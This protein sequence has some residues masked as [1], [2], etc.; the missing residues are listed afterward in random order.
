MSVTEQRR[1]W[2]GGPVRYG[3]LID[4]LKHPS[5]RRERRAVDR[6]T[7][8]GSLRGVGADRFGFVGPG[9]ALCADLVELTWEFWLSNAV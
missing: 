6:M 1:R 4:G 7:F 3:L 8:W 5:A 9:F 2:V